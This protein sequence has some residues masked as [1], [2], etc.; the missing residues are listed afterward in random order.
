[1]GDRGDRMGHLGCPTAQRPGLV[2]LD[3]QMVPVRGA[4]QE[5]VHLASHVVQ[6][7]IL[8]HDRGQRNVAI[9][10]QQERQQDGLVVVE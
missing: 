4:P 7:G 6:V 3:V 9:L 10:F 2:A 8:N 5:H 1:L